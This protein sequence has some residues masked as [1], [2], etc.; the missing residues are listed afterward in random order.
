MNNVLNDFEKAIVKRFKA[1]CKSKSDED[2]IIC[3]ILAIQ[4]YSLQDKLE[5]YISQNPQVGIQE[6]MDYLLSL[7]PQIAVVDEYKWIKE[8]FTPQIKHEWQRE[9]LNAMLKW[10]EKEEHEDQWEIILEFCGFETNEK[11][12]VTLNDLLNLYRRIKEEQ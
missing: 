4:E 1:E 11:P 6:T 3:L 9:E 8:N 7:V 10:A 2:L 5:D 12:T